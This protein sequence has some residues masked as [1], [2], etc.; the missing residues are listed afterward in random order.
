MINFQELYSAG[1]AETMLRFALCYVVN[2][3]IVK[4]LYFKKSKRREYFFTFIIISIAIFFLVYL[5]M[6]MDRGK[7]TMGVGLG[8]FGIFSIMRYRTD[9][10]PVREMTYLFVVVCLSVVHAMAESMG[11]DSKGKEV[12]TPITELLAIDAIVIA[13]IVMFERTLKVEP[14]KLVQ[15]DR[16]ELI[17]PDRYQELVADLEKRLGLK[18]LKVEVGAVD[19]L[20]DM[21]M[22]R[23]Y[24][25]ADGIADK[26]LNDKIK[27]KNTDYAHI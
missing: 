3:I 7:A 9:T 19:F 2:W 16:I 11:I 26:E 14:S 1:F 15:Y 18:V 13:S 22:L 23:V 5:M 12:G 10:M 17:K 4:Y 8:L 27:L 24:Y 25:K 20:R 6:G 21:A